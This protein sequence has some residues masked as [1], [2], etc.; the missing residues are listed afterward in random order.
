MT[1]TR[2]REGGRN[3][4]SHGTQSANHHG[5][6]CPGCRATDRPV[7]RRTPLRRLPGR[8]VL[9]RPRHLQKSGSFKLPGGTST[10]RYPLS[11][12]TGRRVA[13]PEAWQDCPPSRAASV[14]RQRSPTMDRSSAPLLLPGSSASRG[15]C[16]GRCGCPQH[17]LHQSR[18]SMTC[19]FTR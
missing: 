17:P 14:R 3:D 18:V 13:R 4:R 9:L 8:F 2:D 10:L 6:V 1:G 15:T 7:V 12:L 16:L 11:V 5:R 19:D